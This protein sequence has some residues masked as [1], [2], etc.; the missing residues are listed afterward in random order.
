L[1][2]K[3]NTLQQVPKRQTFAI[4]LH[5]IILFKLLYEETFLYITGR[6]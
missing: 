6:K 3:P 5:Y 2:G 1:G 4:K